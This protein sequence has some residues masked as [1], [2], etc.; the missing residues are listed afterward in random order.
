MAGK[1]KEQLATET[2]AKLSKYGSDALLAKLEKGQLKGLSE[3]IALD[4]LEKRQEKAEAADKKGKGWAKNGSHE[5]VGKAKATNKEEEKEEE[6]EEKIEK[7][8]TPDIDGP[9]EE[10]IEKPKEEPIK[11]ASS[12]P[13]APAKPKEAKEVK[14]DLTP[15]QA[16]E[17]KAIVDGEGSKSDKI[18][19]LHAAGLSVLQISKVEGLDAIYQQVRSVVKKAE[20]NG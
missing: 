12:K 15:E 20:A 10:P 8:D 16:K 11:K 18:R 17:A 2:R 3:E 5:K 19:K 1:S 14:S 13:K 7:V 9:K 6:K 4:I